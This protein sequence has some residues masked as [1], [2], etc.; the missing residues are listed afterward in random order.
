MKTKKKTTRISQVKYLELLK[1]IR[2]T[3]YEMNADL[4]ILSAMNDPKHIEHFVR[5]ESTRREKIEKLYNICQ[6]WFCDNR[7][8]WDK[9]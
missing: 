5:I 9:K 1:D 4:C 6:A 2:T 7:L 3:F 8:E